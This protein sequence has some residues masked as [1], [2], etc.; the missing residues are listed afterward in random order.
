ME[1]MVFT[2]DE[3]AKLLRVG[4]KQAYEAVKTGAIPSIRIGKRILVPRVTLEEKLAAMPS[5]K[6]D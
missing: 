6:K 4:R 5:A 1:P 3:A 2:V